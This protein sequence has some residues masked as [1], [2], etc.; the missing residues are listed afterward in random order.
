MPTTVA[1]LPAPIPLG[2][3]VPV[4]TAHAISVSLPTWEDNIGYEEGDKRVIDK[5]ETGYP[6]FFIHRSIQKLA[7]ICLARFGHPNEACILLLSSKAAEA[8]RDFLASQTPSVTSRVIEY[9]VKPSSNSLVD[10]SVA[11]SLGV[12]VVELQMLIFDKEYWSFGKAFWQ[13]TGEGIS[14]RMAER[15]LAFLG[16]TPAGVE[17]KT[18]PPHTPL[19]R[20]ASKVPNTRN[21]HYSRKTASVPPAPTTPADSASNT[22]GL[23]TSLERSSVTEEALTSD[24]TT[25]LEE[26][27][28]RNL[29]M[30]NA[31]LAKLALKRRIA[32]G[33]LP[34]DEDYGKIEDLERGTGSGMKAVT[35]EDVY[36]Y[37]CGM[38]AI[39]HAHGICRQT[40]TIEGEKEGKSICYGFPY[41]DMLKVLNKWGS[42]CHFFGAGGSEDI[43]ALEKLLVETESN[44]NEPAILAL[45]CEFPSN[46]LLRS[47]NL[48]R[49]R[50]LADTYGFIIVIDETIGNFINVE[51]VTYAD[52]VV[53]SLTKIFSGDANVMGG[54]LI[55]N[56]N[57]P[58]YEALKSVQKA[59]YEDYYYPEDA[60]YMERNSRDYRARIKTVNDN[61]YYVCELLHSR[62]LDDSSTPAEGK[63]LKKVY[64]PRYITPDLYAVA[65]RYPILGKG[66]YGGLF[67]LTFTSKAASRAFYNAIGCAKGPSLGTSFTLASP[68]TLLAHYLELDWAAEYGVESDLIRISVGQ[69]EQ[70]VLAQW[71]QTALAAAEAAEQ[72]EEEKHIR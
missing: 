66:G 72:A 59:T 27:Y 33:L 42:G 16:E 13:H 9:V 8:G 68:Y 64:Y 60:V 49:I 65:Q 40:R 41:T 35:E 39:W 22:P 7:D 20:P 54:S 26:R 58:H 3:P 52:I 56:P 25:Y 23:S 2:S 36:L 62:S 19:E 57:S 24:L 69:E 34:S 44:P 38:S 70:S 67:S 1:P 31:P 51:L 43:D 30:F 37:P 17:Q 71:F 50:K 6:R 32:G 48:V 53:S 10:P 21:K 18:S 5:M 14:S 46:P 12:N 55:L 61:A 47:P 63:V 15:A 28:G 11:Q 29:P 4:L 45:F